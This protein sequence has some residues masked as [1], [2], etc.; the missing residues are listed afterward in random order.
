MVRHSPGFFRILPDSSRFFLIL[1]G[2][3]G[4]FRILQDSFEFFQDS[5]RFLGIFPGFSQDLLKI[6]VDFWG[7]LGI[8]G[9]S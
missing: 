9:D 5:L 7:F 2:S 4:F 6:L 3:S 8:F 1:Q